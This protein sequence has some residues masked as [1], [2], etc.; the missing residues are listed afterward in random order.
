MSNIPM[1]SVVPSESASAAAH[2]ALQK[3][4]QVAVRNYRKECTSGL[5]LSMGSGQ[6]LIPCL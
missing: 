1:D 3:Q 6:L 4:L 5:T 2:Q